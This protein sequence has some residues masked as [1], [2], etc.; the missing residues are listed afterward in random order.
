MPDIFFSPACSVEY[1][2]LFSG[3]LHILNNAIEKS[4]DQSITTPNHAYLPLLFPHR[5][6]SH[7]LCRPSVI[8]ANLQHPALISS[9][10]C[11]IVDSIISSMHACRNKIQGGDGSGWTKPTMDDGHGWNVHSIVNQ[12]AFQLSLL[13]HRWTKY[14][15]K[16]QCIYASRGR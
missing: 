3:P 1:A 12:A 7:L 2:R 10:I 4:Y 16:V 13:A 11:L 14:R 9:R 8:S 15:A 5:R 6:H